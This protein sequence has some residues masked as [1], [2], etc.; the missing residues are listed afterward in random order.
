MGKEEIINKIDNL[1]RKVYTDIN[2]QM[3][4]HLTMPIRSLSNVAYNPNV[5]YFEILGKEKSR[6]LTVSTIKTFAQTLKMMEF[7][8][9][10]QDTNDISTKRDTYYISK[11]WGAAKFKEQPE[12]D[13][14][15]DDFEAMVGVNREQLGFIPDEKGGSIAGE[16]VVIDKDVETC[17][18]LK[19]DCTKFGSGS[20]SIPSSVEHLHFETN[21]KFILAV[22]TGDYPDFS[23]H[24]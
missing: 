17:D 24:I 10:L 16:L 7:S 18:E 4:P 6:T 8:K 14:V 20:Y 9:Y 1:A 13:T 2:Q 23:K 21:A 12:S 22:E 5:G 11:N 19:I 15:M 3:A